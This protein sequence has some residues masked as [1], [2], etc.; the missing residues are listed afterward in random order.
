VGLNEIADVGD[1]LLGPRLVCAATLKAD[2]AVGIAGGAV[3]VDQAVGV[4]VRVVQQLPRCAAFA[5]C[6]RPAEDACQL[7]LVAE[8]RAAEFV[9]A[10]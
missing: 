4:A 2:D 8:P 10:V 6:G 1:G 3:A 5:R 9:G 7:A